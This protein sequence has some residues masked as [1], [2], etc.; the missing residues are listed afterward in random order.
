MLI[1]RP[2]EAYLGYFTRM[3]NAGKLKNK[4]WEFNTFFRLM[5]YTSF[6]WD[7]KASLSHVQNEVTQIEGEKLV[8]DIIG[9]QIVNQPGS[10]ANSFYGYI[11]KGVYSTP[12]EANAANLINTKNMN[13]R[14]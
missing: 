9:A 11:Y 5:D 4:G 10:P 14:R 7:I 8:T 13:G 3:E 6:K 1:F 2:V 12:E